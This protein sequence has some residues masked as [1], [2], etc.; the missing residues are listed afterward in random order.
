MKTPRN[1]YGRDFAD[2]LIRSWNFREV[3]QTGS[4]I[5]LRT[6]EPL[7]RTISIPDHKPIRPGTLRNLLDDI[8][9]HKN[10]SIQDILQKL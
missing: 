8:A 7:A 4:H 6:E 9:F 3:R 5:I 10:V 1:I 2:H